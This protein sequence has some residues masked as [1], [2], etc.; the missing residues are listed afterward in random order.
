VWRSRTS[1]CIGSPSSTACALAC[2]LALGACGK[3]SN[4]IADLVKSTGP[5]QRQADGTE[6]WKQVQPPTTYFLGDAAQTSPN[7]DATLQVGG[8]AATIIMQP[9]T[10]LRFRAELGQ[11]RLAVERG[12]IA[13]TG[14]G[15]YALDVGDVKLARKGTVR[16]TSRGAGK[17]VVELTSTDLQIG[18]AQVET[19]AGTFQL[20][21]GK[22][23]DVDKDAAPPVDA[24]VRDAAPP[25]APEIDAADGVADAADEVAGA[26]ISVTG[27][28]AEMLAPGET[29]WK[30]LPAGTA[31]LAKGSAIR[32]GPGTTARVAASDVTLEL[33]GGSRVKLG[34]DQVFALELGGATASSPGAGTVALPGGSVALVG[35]ERSAAEAKLDT[36]N[37]DTRVSVL[38]GNSKLSGASGSELPMSRGETASLLR[39][40]TIRQIE[41]IPSY[42]DLRVGVGE[43]LTI[44]DPRPPTA[45]QFQFDGRCPDGGIIEV[46]RDARF[47]TAKLSG[48]RDFANVMIGGGGWAYRLRCTT[49]GAEGGSVVT[50]R[51]AS[52]RDD[53]RRPLPRQQGLNEIDADG[54]N[55]RIYYQSTIPNI[56]VRIR[57][58]GSSHKLHLASAGSEQT[59]DSSSASILVPGNQLREGTYTFW[60]DRDGT[61]QDKVSTLVIDF[62]QTSPQVYIE[63][64]ANGVAWQGDIDVRGAVLPGWSAA[65]GAITIPIDRYRRFAAKV[66]IPGGNALAIRL[67]HPQRGVHYYLRRPSR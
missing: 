35:S 57:N 33:G 59:F 19:N 27:R 1:N 20:E 39:N 18:D 50:G 37:R 30:P 8:G 56:A 61:K 38:R 32:L 28:R 6:V 63:S 42:F 40:G 21:I 9:D 24:A 31:P 12:A 46:D 58:P 2:A 62:D 49:N 47:R 41:A 48:G 45:V 25:D 15:N 16:I 11:S 29:A 7:G 14:T 53:G 54:R 67:S 36:G 17:A 26:T 60:I 64:P 44:H 4:P 43:S 51:V 66:G 52:L 55:Y 10:V 5:V 13:L 65:V 3:K 34:D 23:V 22:P